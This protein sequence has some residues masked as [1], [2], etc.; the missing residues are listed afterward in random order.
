MDEGPQT[1]TEARGAQY[2]LENPEVLR[3]QARAIAR[4]SVYGCVHVVYPMISDPGQFLA[5][6]EKF[7]GNISLLKSGA[8]RHGVMFE[9]PAACRQADGLIASADFAS[10]GTNDLIEQL[11]NFN[12]NSEQAYQASSHPALWEMIGMVLSAAKERGKTVLVCGELARRSEFFNRLIKLGAGGISVPPH[13]IPE[14]RQEISAMPE[15]HRVRKTLRQKPE[16]KAVE[17]E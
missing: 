14:I 12:R 9:F 2:L 7:L 13:M 10:I 3:T 11:F 8:L 5:L 1:S 16:P 6:K 15:G 17:H 4:A